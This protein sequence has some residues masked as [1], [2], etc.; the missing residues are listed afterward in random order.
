MDMRIEELRTANEVI[1][2]LVNIK[3]TMTEL[4]LK[5][6]GVPQEIYSPLLTQRDKVSGSLLTKR[7]MAPLILAALE[8]HPNGYLIIRNLIKLASEWKKFDL[9]DDEFKARATVQKA[10]ELL[11]TIEI[12]DALDASQREQAKEKEIERISKIHA[13]IVNKESELLLMMFEDLARMNTNHQK[14]G[15]LLQD[16]L[17]RVFSVHEIQVQKSFQRN[18]GGEQID[19]AFKLDGWYY[20]VEC[21]WRSKLADIRDMD[22]LLGPIG[23][24]GKQTMGLFLSIEGWSENVRALLKQNSDKSIILM[25]GF[26]LR[27]ILAERIDLKAFLSA[28]LSKL[29]FEG[30]PFFSVKEYLNL[31]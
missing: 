5:P 21:R 19:G 29:S 20:L 25:D 2:T 16:L 6:A 1:C 4:I 3:R 7:E 11:G 24:S 18:E 27:T 31:N 14:R 10:R 22:G 28:K 9:A 23:R 8:K 15:F 13:E 30:E 12:N 17:N 26:D